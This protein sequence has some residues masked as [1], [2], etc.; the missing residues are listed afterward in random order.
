MKLYKI[1][2]PYSTLYK[3]GYLTTNKEGRRIVTFVKDG[4]TVQGTAYARYLMAVKL[5][6]FLT[7]NEQVDHIDNDRTNDSIG[8]LQLLTASENRS[9][10]LDTI[11]HDMHGTNSMYRK[12]CR[13]D[14]CKAWK[15]NYIK[16]YR[17]E[18]PEA[19]SAYN[20][21]RRDK[22]KQPAVAELA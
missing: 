4:K 5:G 11:V 13:C 8:N 19:V 16:S 1:E 10:Y 14:L 18:N 20:K 9:K 21:R 22:R 7:A 2:Y 3:T 12:G 15:S 17:Q 6:R